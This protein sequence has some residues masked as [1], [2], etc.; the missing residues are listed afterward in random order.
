MTK[1]CKQRKKTSLPQLK[2]RLKATSFTQY[3]KERTLNMSRVIDTYE[4]RSKKKKE[5]SMS[6]K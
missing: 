1:L 2:I 3:L 5:F 4:H 6:W